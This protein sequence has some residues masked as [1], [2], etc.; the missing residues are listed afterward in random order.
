MLSGGLMDANRLNRIID[1]KNQQ[2]E[3]DALRDAAH[4]IESIA[5]EQLQIT[6]AEA[7]IAELRKQLT[8]LNIP[9]LDGKQILGE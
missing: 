4:L 8:E 5:Y 7:R 6:K 3:S 9:Q 1:D 2:L